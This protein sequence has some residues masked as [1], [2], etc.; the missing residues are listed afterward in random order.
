MI[1]IIADSTCDLSDEILA[2]YQISI[3]PLTIQIGDKSYQDRIDIQPDEFYHMMMDLEKNP[4]TAMPSPTEFL[5]CMEEGIAEGCTEILCICMSSGTSGSYQSA[6]IAQELFY[7]QYDPNEYKLHIVDTLCMSHGSGYLILKSAL[8][9]EVGFTFEELVQFNET[10]KKHVKHF[11]SV[12]D[13][14]NLIRSG[15]LSNTSAFIGKL[16]RIKPIMTMRDGKGVI[17]AKE[18]GRRNVLDHYV[19]EFIKRVDEEMTT[20]I[21]IGYTSDMAYAENLKLKLLQESDFKGDVYIMQMGVSVGT[22]VGLGGVSMYFIEKDRNHDGLLVNELNN[23]VLKRDT[24][25]EA[26]KRKYGKA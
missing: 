9:R 22:H 5:R 4:T 10:F 18:R 26:F 11:L 21:I 6:I 3:A 7:E 15:R 20:F 23:F 12:D 25:L 8:L 19:R 17:V 16:L 1:K 24:F 14:D 2:R 13:L